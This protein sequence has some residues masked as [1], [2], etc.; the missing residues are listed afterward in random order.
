MKLHEIKQK[1]LE[2]CGW[3]FFCGR[4]GYLD[5]AHLIRRSASTVHRGN[6]DNCILACRECHHIF[7]NVPTLRVHLPNYKKAMQII[8]KI[9]ESYYNEIADKW[10]SFKTKQ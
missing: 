8:K 6:P 1:L 4:T 10:N 9:D 7:D 2:E 3:C 5:L